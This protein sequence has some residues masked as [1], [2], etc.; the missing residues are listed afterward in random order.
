MFNYKL[1]PFQFRQ[2][3]DS[4]MLLV[5]ESGDYLF[6]TNNQFDL[7]RDTPANLPK[8]IIHDL[9]SR[10]FLSE[11]QHLAS[12]IDL[13]ATKYRTRKQFMA[14]FTA[15]HMMVITLRCN[16]KCEYCQVSSEDDDAYLFD[17]KAETAR[18]IV[19]CIFVSPSPHIK[20]EFQGG[21]PLLNWDVIV[22]TVDY[23][24]ELNQEIGKDL[25]FVICTNLT[26]LT[27]EHLDYIKDHKIDLSTSLDG[28]K[29]IH[30]KHR[31]TR[32][33]S[34]SYD[35]YTTNLEKARNS[36]GKENVSALMTA[37]IDSLD[38]FPEIIDEYIDREFEGI[39]FRSLNPYGGAATNKKELGYPMAKFV[40]AYKQ[41]FEYIL[42][43]NKEG[44]YFIE[45]FGTLLL[46]RILTPF[47]TGFV[48]L[49][50]PSGA[51]ISGAIYDYNGD[52]YPADEG[53]MLARMGDGKFK[54][55]NVYLDSYS[56]IFHG[57]VL[58]EIVSKSCLECMPRCAT[59]VYRVYCG[60]DPIRNY[61]ETG[62]VIG[63]RPG[64]PFCERQI[65]IFDYLFKKILT[66]DRDE[67][68]IF[69]SWITK[70]SLKDMRNENAS[71]IAQ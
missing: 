61:L 1:F 12:A 58:K 50:S 29:C 11:K 25:S 24:E 14:D 16:H 19:D 43:K 34:S 18:R 60:S 59:C 21:E 42:Q 27:D 9:E 28:T 26:A 20:I 15:L 64:S 13:T 48:D 65:E 66:S 33:G 54:M 55:G 6:V 56:S 62:D 37:T 40:E 5:N 23:A 36:I 70:R 3:P 38:R 69:W 10:H 68:D 63:K 45:F 17:M 2:F 39:F 35:A 71:G 41:G 22:T 49:Q 51:G 8:K 4:K 30:D 31:L 52:V 57:N 47:S 7:L 46:S 53:R 32:N 67:M 44:V